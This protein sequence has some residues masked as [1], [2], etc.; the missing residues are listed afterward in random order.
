MT[1]GNIGRR[2]FTTE[3]I[4]S[5]DDLPIPE[6]WTWRSLNIVRFPEPISWNPWI[7]TIRLAEPIL[8]WRYWQTETIQRRSDN[9]RTILGKR[10]QTIFRQ[11]YLFWGKRW[12][13]PDDPWTNASLF[14]DLVMTVAMMGTKAE[15]MMG[16][17][18]LNFLNNFLNFLNNFLNFLNNSSISWTNFLNQMMADP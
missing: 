11:S 13:F 7:E 2:W 4:N 12:L 6:S 9:L 15:Q 5:C 3:T 14:D 1:E 17:N 16:T 18:F 8:L 10:D